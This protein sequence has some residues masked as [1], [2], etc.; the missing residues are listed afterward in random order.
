MRAPGSSASEGGFFALPVLD[1]VFD[2]GAAV[3]TCVGGV[4]VA[5]LSAAVPVVSEVLTSTVGAAVVVFCPTVWAVAGSTLVLLTGSV[6]AVLR[7]GSPATAGPSITTLAP[8][9]GGAAC[10]GPANSS[11]PAVGKKSVNSIPG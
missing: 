7:T 10:E 3:T 1:P 9:A 11:L 6:V 2:G 4:C 5:G 8:S